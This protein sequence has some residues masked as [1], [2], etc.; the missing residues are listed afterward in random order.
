MKF[1]FEMLFVHAI[2]FGL[3]AEISALVV[4][5]IPFVFLFCIAIRR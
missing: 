3:P 4:L 5:R 1:L 2:I